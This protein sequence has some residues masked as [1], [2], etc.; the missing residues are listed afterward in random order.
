M[1]S[2]LLDT[3]MQRAAEISLLF[4]HTR[5]DSSLCFDINNLMLGENVA[6]LQR[7]P[8]E[9][10]NSWM[11]SPGHRANILQS[12]YSTIGI[13]CFEI[14][15]M[16]FW[17]QCFGSSTDSEN[18]AQPSDYQL[19]EHIQIATEEFKPAI[20]R[21][22]NGVSFSTDNGESYLFQIVPHF[23]SNT[24]VGELEKPQIKIRNPGFTTVYIT[25]DPADFVW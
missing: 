1:N 22:Q 6:A 9:V 4:S 21:N 20:A 12:T 15:G 2:S 25:V 8:S 17:V 10:I 18:C 3:A 24:Y 14:D 7:S 5:P 13:G 11:N 16:L 19:T 23:S